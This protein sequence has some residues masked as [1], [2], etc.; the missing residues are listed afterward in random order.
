[1]SNAH[2]PIFAQLHQTLIYIRY[3]IPIWWVNFRRILEITIIGSSFRLTD[4]FKLLNALKIAPV[5][6]FLNIVSAYMQNHY[7]L[8]Q[9]YIVYLVSQLV[10]G[11][12]MI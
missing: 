8:N 2:F 12:I 5:S 9:K 3:P 6:I 11:D 4:R 1:M 7:F 10:N